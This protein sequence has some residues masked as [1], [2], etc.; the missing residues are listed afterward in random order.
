MSEAARLVAKGVRVRR[1]GRVVVEDVDLHVEPG[2]LVAVL[3]P[4]G[5]GKSTLL[6][7]L[8]GLLPSEGSL[9]LGGRPLA[10]LRARERARRIAFVPQRSGLRSALRVEEVVAQGRY[11]YGG[12]AAD[13]AAQRALRYVGIEAM[14]ERAYTGLSVGEQQRVLLARALASEAPLL[15]LDEP[16][17]PLDVRHALETFAIVRRLADEGRAVLLVVHDLDDARR[18]ADRAVLLREGRLFRA[19][20]A[21][22]VVAPA[23]IREVYEVVAEEDAALGF[24]LPA[25][26]DAGEQE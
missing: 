7:A 26:D 17:A 6:R 15:M 19:G 23:P 20:P 16:T 10:S 22:E 9:T 3:G 25:S 4:N 18:V 21:R 5:A 11:A 14:A 8:A 12:G 13:P 24:R 1:G 2:E